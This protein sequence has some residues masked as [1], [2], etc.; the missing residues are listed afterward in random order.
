MPSRA[1]ALSAAAPQITRTWAPLREPHPQPMLYRRQ[2]DRPVIG[3]SKHH[4]ADV[5]LW[6]ASGQSG[7]HVLNIGNHPPFFDPHQ[8]F[9]RRR[10]QPGRRRFLVFANRHQKRRAS[11]QGS[12]TSR[13][14]R[15]RCHQAV[16]IPPDRGTHG[17]MVPEQAGMVQKNRQGEQTAQGMTEKTAAMGIRRKRGLDTGDQ[18]IP[19]EREE[20]LSS[21][22]I[23]LPPGEG[24]IQLPPLGIK[25]GARAADADD[26]RWRNGRHIETPTSPPRRFH[27]SGEN[28]VAIQQVDH[29]KAGS[30]RRFGRPSH[31]NAVNAALGRR[32]NEAP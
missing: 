4:A 25:L 17:Q 1:D 24:E 5:G 15:R 13:Q 6:P 3:R 23:L 11:R 16:A 30:R 8:A 7:G 31:G 29:W 12:K 19:Q 10:G 22:R 9:G 2:D 18:P 14:G 26:H 21:A 20:R 32:K 27:H 28:R